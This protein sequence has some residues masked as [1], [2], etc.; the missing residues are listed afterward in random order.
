MSPELQPMAVQHYCHIS[1]FLSRDHYTALPLEGFLVRDTDVYL[2]NI[3]F[4]IILTQFYVNCS[5][6][7]H[8]IDV[9]YVSFSL[10][11]GMLTFS[12]FRKNDRFV[13]ITTTKNRKR[14]DRF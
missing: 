8:Q 9:L 6:Q 7:E 11:L 3:R 12:F 1:P 4:G 14:N 13:V 5:R 2:T 10:Y